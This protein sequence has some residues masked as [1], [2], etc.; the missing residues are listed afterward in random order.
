MLVPDRFLY[1]RLYKWGAARRRGYALLDG[2]TRDALYILYCKKCV[3][4]T[5]YFNLYYVNY[6]YS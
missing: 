2:A 3:V 5:L 1:E 4:F 6:I